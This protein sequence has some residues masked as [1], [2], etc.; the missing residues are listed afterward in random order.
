MLKELPK[1]TLGFLQRKWR[2]TLGLQH[3]TLFSIHHTAFLD[4]LDS[5][6]VREGP[7]ITT[8]APQGA[9]CLGVFTDILY[10][11]VTVGV[12]KQELVSSSGK[13]HINPCCLFSTT[14][15]VYFLVKRNVFYA[16]ISIC[17]VHAESVQ[18]C[19]NERNDS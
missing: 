19:Y 5:P 15:Y 16:Q 12:I 2:Q 6:L 1:V 8:W 11:E 3:T 13:A 4:G 17:L 9:F 7:I 14:T 18:S 10:L